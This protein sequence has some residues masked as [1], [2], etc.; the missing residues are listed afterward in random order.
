MKTNKTL[1]DLQNVSPYAIVICLDSVTGLQTARILS[2]RGVSVTGIAKDRDHFACRTNV[3][4]KILI[5]D[6]DSFELISTLETLR[7]TLK[8]KPVLFPCSD[9]S[10]LV[11]SRHRDSLDKWYHIIL[12]PANVIEMMVD[13]VKFYRYAQENKFPIPET[14]FLYSRKDAEEATRKLTFPAILKPPYRP[15]EWR[16]H[17]REKAFKVLNAEELLSIYDQYGMWTD[18]L[19]AQHCVEGADTNHITCNCYF[20]SDSKPLVIFTSRKLRQWPQKTGQG[21][22]GEAYR[23][24]HVARETVN[25]YQSVGFRGLGYLEMKQ[26]QNTGKYFIIEPNVGRP[27][28][29]SATAEANGVELIYTMYCDAI[30]RSLPEN[31][32]QKDGN[33]KWIYL[34]QDIQSALYSWFHGELTLREWRQSVR[35]PK[36]YAIFSWTDPMPFWYDLWGA[37]KYQIKIQISKRQKRVR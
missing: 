13:K 3:C 28:G 36:W 25:L 20:G 30:G 16:K 23:N 19:I 18:I 33:V 12:P 21:C 10:V 6:T 34:R 5:T 24:D 35:G 31:R 14:Y 29:R 7:P 15:D 9:T 17:T 22:F 2:Q 8:E 32:E 1:T 37:I 26:D 11:I 4:E 27:T